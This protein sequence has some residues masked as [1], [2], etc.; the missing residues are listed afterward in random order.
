[1]SF[2]Y[3][4]YS[5]HERAVMEA[6][7]RRLVSIIPVSRQKELFDMEKHEAELELFTVQISFDQ[8]WSE[9]D[10]FIHAPKKEENNA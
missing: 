4:K 2:S 10:V 7:F 6:E 9:K 5:M 8:H 1:M 3:E